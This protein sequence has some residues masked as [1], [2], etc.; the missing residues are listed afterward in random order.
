ML[1]FNFNDSGQIV[2]QMGHLAF[3]LNLGQSCLN[4]IDGNPNFRVTF[5]WI[6]HSFIILTP[7][8]VKKKRIIPQSDYRNECLLFATNILMLIL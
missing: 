6:K 2:L 4:R 1:F 8:L 7:V 3:V 5:V